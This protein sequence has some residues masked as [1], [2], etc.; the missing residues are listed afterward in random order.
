MDAILS[1]S[2]ALAEAGIIIGARD[3]V[4]LENLI[5]EVAKTSIPDEINLIIGGLPHLNC[6]REKMVQVI[7]N[8]MQ[9]AYQHGNAKTITVSS[10][11]KDD[12]F[13]LRNLRKKK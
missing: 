1:K 8:L 3:F 7:Q 9:N 5:R 4:N 6:D 12:V 11:I 13:S 2:I 10:R